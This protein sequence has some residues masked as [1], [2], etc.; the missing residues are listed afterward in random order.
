M[1]GEELLL[2]RGDA[3]TPLASGPQM[4]GDFLSPDP[5]LDSASPSLREQKRNIHFQSDILSKQ[6]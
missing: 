2:A 3:Y 1:L 5:F 4:A 6:L